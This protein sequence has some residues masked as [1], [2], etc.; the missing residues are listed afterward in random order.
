MY[1]G[2]DLG[3]YIRRGEGWGRPALA[4]G[5]RTAYYACL[6]LKDPN[7]CQNMQKKPN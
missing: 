4:R 2:A 1:S 5:L 3:I 7:D 6:Y